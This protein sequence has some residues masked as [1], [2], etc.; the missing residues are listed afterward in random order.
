MPRSIRPRGRSRLPQGSRIGLVPRSGERGQAI[1]LFAVCL[2]VICGAVAIVLDQ[3]LL[4]KANQDLWNSLDAGA[5]AGVTLLP[6]DAVAAE[7]VALDYV[8][9]NY[10]SGSPSDEVDVSFRCLIGSVAGSPRL[11]DVPSV[12]DP[13]SGETWT[14]NATICT[15]ICAPSA[16]DTCN[17]IVVASPTSVDYNFGPVLDVFGGHVATKQSAACKGPCGQA[18]DTPVDLVMVLDRTQSMNGVDTENA[19]TAADAVRRAYDPRMQHIGFSML[20]PSRTDTTCKTQPAPS[21]GTASYPTDLARWLPV[22]LSGTGATL[23]ENYTLSTS[24]LTRAIGCFTNS[25]TNTDI[26]DPIRAATYA[27]EHQGRTGATKA[28]LLLSDGEPN[29]STTGTRNYCQEAVDAATAAKA[30]GIT[31]VTVGFGLDGRNAKSCPD[32]SGTWRDVNSTL[33]LAEMATDSTDAGCPGTSNDDG[34]NFY[35]LPKTAGAS[36][37]LSNVFK[38]AVGNVVGQT[39]LVLLP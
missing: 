4:R 6:D 10:P 17:T 30:K 37:D 8:D 16:G 15:A 23:D 20:G 24:A 33:M 11:S 32:Q 26:A 31:V 13:G 9:E 34:D 39:R 28:I 3:G 19:R 25:S 14:C 21:I 29:I 2:A 1:V 7:S 36:T 27:L 38:A 18:P 12:C 22:N 5:L 35:C